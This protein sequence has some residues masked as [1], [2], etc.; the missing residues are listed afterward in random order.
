MNDTILTKVKE[1]AGESWSDE[2]AESLSETVQESISTA[3]AT[4]TDGLQAKLVAKTNAAK[5]AAAKVTQLG[6]VPQGQPERWDR[7]KAM[8]AAMENAGFGACTNHGECEAACPKE[9][10]MDFIARLNRDLVCS[11]IK[12]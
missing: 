7:V 11:M 3:T 9:I 8:V 2:W 5:E 1:L 12:K 6:L 4:A 10:P